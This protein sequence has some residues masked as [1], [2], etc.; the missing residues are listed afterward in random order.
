MTSSGT[1]WQLGVL[2]LVPHVY[3]VGFAILVA[4]RG[5]VPDW[6][7]IPHVTVVVLGLVLV[8]YTLREIRS[9]SDWT[10]ANRTNWTMHVALLPFIAV[11][12]YFLTMKRPPENVA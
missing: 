9:R 5:N 1:R 2:S 6:I 10:R 4:T 12:K 8:V 11:P 3:G 7:W